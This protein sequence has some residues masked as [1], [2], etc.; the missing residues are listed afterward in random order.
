M[1]ANDGVALARRRLEAGAIDDRDSPARVFDQPRFLER[2]AGE[3][4]RWTANAEHLS[5]E[6]LLERELVRVQPIARRQEPPAHPL[7]ERVQSIAGSRLRQCR[8]ERHGV[9]A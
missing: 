6:I 1:T 4:H 9:L 5:E 2:R 7:F 3:A 8:D